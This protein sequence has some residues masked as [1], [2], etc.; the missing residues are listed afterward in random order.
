MYTHTLSL[1]HTHVF[2]R[3]YVSIHTHTHTW[4]RSHELTS[5]LTP[6]LCLL[7]TPHTFSLYLCRCD[8]ATTP[9]PKFAHVHAHAHA[10]AQANA[11]ANEQSGVTD[12]AVCQ[13]CSLNIQSV[14]ST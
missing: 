6:A 7:A 1:S 5:A 12:E 11:N 14:L 8:E 4:W 3:A 9:S 13:K 2:A 10:H